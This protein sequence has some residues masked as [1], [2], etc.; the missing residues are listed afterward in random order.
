M[1]EMSEQRRV[2]DAQLAEALED[3]RSGRVSPIFDTVEQMLASLK[4]PI[5]SSPITEICEKIQP[6]F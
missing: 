4:A 2:I 3:I 5:Q 1:N 6:N